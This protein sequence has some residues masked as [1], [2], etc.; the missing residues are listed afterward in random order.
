MKFVA[1]LNSISPHQI[2]LAKELVKRIGSENYRYV[3][4]SRMSEE[5]RRL[6]WCEES[7]EWLV[8]ANMDPIAT[9]QMLEDCDVLY[10]GIR[11]V[12]LFRLRAKKRLTTLY[13]SERWF[14]PIKIWTLPCNRSIALSGLIRMF[15]PKFRKMAK[16]VRD[17]LEEDVPFYYLPVGVH[18]ALDMNRLTKLCTESMIR[19]D[20]WQAGNFVDPKGRI[21]MWGYFVEPSSQGGGKRAKCGSLR[22]LWV[23]RMLE[24]KRVDTLIRAA[25]LLSHSQSIEL[26][27]VGDGPEKTR[28][29]K[30][31]GSCCR[32]AGT[33]LAIDFKDSVSLGL[34][35]ALM[36]ENDVYVFTSNALDGWGAV[37]NEAL[38]EGLEVLATSDCGA[39][40][41]LLPS[42]QTFKAGDWRSLAARL[43]VLSEVLRVADKDEVVSRV[44]EKWSAA[45]ASAI[46]K[47]FVRD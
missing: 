20:C 47:E 43:K 18:A 26:T 21:R 13:Y 29:E 15:S 33:T 28:L 14:K 22:I 12:D 32:T 45:Y 37:V 16:V 7:A 2:P 44:I 25:S 46:L 35:R 17:L 42:G 23:G 36:R 5:R 11:D 6:G 39:G 34:V 41:T 38:E 1:Y 4:T 3:Y 10:T 30:L 31:A 27:L 8:D 9:R 24:L 40:A 19:R